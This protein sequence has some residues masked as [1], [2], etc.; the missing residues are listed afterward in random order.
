MIR[1]NKK[2][3]RL[4]KSL[5]VGFLVIS[6]LLV[7]WPA[8]QI[9]PN[10]HFP[11]KV[12]EV[13]AAVAFD[14]ASHDSAVAAGATATF[15]WTHTPVGTPKGVIVFVVHGT[16]STDQISGV[17]YGSLSLTRVARACDTATEPG[18]SY[19]Y[20]GGASIPTGAQTVTVTISG[21]TSG[22]HASAVTITSGGANTEVVTFDNSVAADAT[23]PSVSLNLA[24]RTSFVAEGVYSGAANVTSITPPTGWTSRFEDDFGAFVDGYYTYNTIGSSNVSAGWTQALDDAAM[25]AL[26]V[27]EITTTL[28]NGT[29]GGN[30]SISPGGA[31]TEIDR[32]SFATTSGTDSVT[33]L[34]VTLA[35]TGAYNNIATVD[36]Q[37][38][39]GASKCSATPSGDAVSLSTCGISV[40][41]TLTEYKIIITPKTHANMP[42][43]SSGQSYATTAT[44]TAWTQSSTN[45]QA[46]TDSGSATVTIDNLSPNGATSV[47]GS[48]GNTAVT[49]NWTSSSSTDFDTTNGSV[50]LR[51]A[52][53]TAGSEVPAEGNSSYVAGNTITTATV[54]CVISSAVSTALSK[55]DGTGGSVGCTTTALTNGQAYTYKAFQRDTNG[56]YD[57]G[58]SIG[59]FTPSAASSTF[60]QNKYRWYQ[61]NNL[62]DPTVAWGSPALA[63]NT[64]IVI[65]PAG[66]NPPDTA[67]ALRLRVNYV[68]NT[69]NLPISTNYFKLEFK[70]GTDGSC[71]TGTWTDVGT[72]AWAYGTSTVTD[73]SNINAVLSDTTTGLGE[74]YAKSKPTALNHVGANTAQIIEY[75]FHI[76]G[77]SS[78]ANTTYSFRV[79]GTN[80][81]GSTETVFDAYTNCPTLTTKPGTS[82]LMRHGNVFTDGSEKGFFWAN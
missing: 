22:T 56:N 33:G 5:F 43:P 48:A 76:L 12:K 11:P 40:T 38:T 9:G 30:S 15:S 69:A 31:A 74:Q 55:I 57:V 62:A 8:I 82:D 24:G 32:F 3:N 71:T 72:G 46:G 61:D 35:P 10:F 52:S 23:N 25:V 18:C 1:L 75:D 65:V 29:D 54:A 81:T 44:V 67:T 59:T 70:A 16:A 14:A 6:W 49:L 66:N 47:S 19:A 41:T 27:S 28:G 77:T 21:G 63:E 34:T 13:R 4:I 36:V 79:V 2:S 60:T 68:V 51:W 45:A 42:A 37:T 78:V 26:A 50:I 64:A 20:F 73:G 39:A 53:G 58:V 7:G 17:T 80:N